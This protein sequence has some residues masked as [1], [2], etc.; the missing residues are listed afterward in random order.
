MPPKISSW[1]LTYPKCDA[2]Q[3]ECLAHLETIDTIIHYIIARELHKDGT[4]HLHA[5]VKFVDGVE[6]RKAITKTNVPVFD[7]NG[8]HGNYQAC[9]SCKNVI[10]YCTKSEDYISNF[11]LVKYRAHRGKITITPDQILANSAGSAIRLGP[12]SYTH[13]TLRRIERCRSRWSPYH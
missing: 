7:F 9:R 11:D 6:T 3:S 4:N 5:Y 12:V 8:Y 1:F 2:E 13:L 10:Q